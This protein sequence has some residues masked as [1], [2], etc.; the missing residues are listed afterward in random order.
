MNFA[1]SET[2][3]LLADQVSRFID[4]DYDFEARRA[5]LA[6]DVGYSPVHWQTFADLGWLGLPFDEDTGGFGGDAVDLMVLFEAFGRGLLLE[7]YLAN[8]VLAGSALALTGSC[9]AP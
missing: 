2:Q 5:L 4:R 9:A 3:Q 7:P 6:S 1:L 8:V